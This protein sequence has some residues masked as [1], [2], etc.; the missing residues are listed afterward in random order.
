[1]DTTFA[2]LQSR[3]VPFEQGGHIA[4]A[5]Q[6]IRKH[7][8]VPSSVWKPRIQYDQ[9][10]AAKKL[11]DLINQRLSRFNVDVEAAPMAETKLEIYEKAKNDVQD[12]FDLFFGPMPKE[13]TYRGK[14]Y[15]PQ[16]FAQKFTDVHETTTKRFV[17]RRPPL[18]DRLA[19]LSQT[20]QKANNPLEVEAD[21]QQGL[22]RSTVTLSELDKKIIVALQDGKTVPLAFNVER[23]FIDRRISSQARS[24]IKLNSAT[25][26]AGI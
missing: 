5:R 4:W 21:F 16:T 6:L 9:K 1:M 7:G 25:K 18:S 26:V 20:V 13:F 14:S 22:R 8:I 3:G 19:L 10:D 15:T 23:P 11:T 2:A 24:L 17:V 12:I